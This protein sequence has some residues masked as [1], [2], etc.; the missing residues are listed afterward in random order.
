MIPDLLPISLHS[1]KIKSGS[2]LGT[3]LCN[4]KPLTVGSLQLSNRKWVNRKE[5]RFEECA[6]AWRNLYSLVIS[7][8]H[9]S[10]RDSNGCRPLWCGQWR[11]CCT[12]AHTT[13]PRI[14][15]YGM[16]GTVYAIN[17]YT[18]YHIQ[19]CWIICALIYILSSSMWQCWMTCVLTLPAAVSSVTLQ[20]SLVPFLDPSLPF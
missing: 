6:D 15:S 7:G 4:S 20:Y 1:C 11:S 12:F 14:V 19:H 17:V 18:C 8:T 9:H 2:G 10:C 5:W 3:R 13:E 16:Y